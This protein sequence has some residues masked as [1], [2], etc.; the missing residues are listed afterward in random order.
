MKIQTR[1]EYCED[2]FPVWVVW[3]MDCGDFFFKLNICVA[4][5]SAEVADNPDLDRKKNQR[6]S[7]GSTADI[8]TSAQQ[9]Q[10][11]IIS[12]TP[13]G[14][15]FQPRQGGIPHLT[16]PTNRF[17]APLN[18]VLSPGTSVNREK[19]C[20]IPTILPAACM[21]VEVV[22]IS[23]LGKHIGLLGCFLICRQVRVNG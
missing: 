13:H 7:T 12:L 11:R 10:S 1:R 21:S 16:A 14:A 6:Q 23:V 9:T 17:A 19:S 8:K 20:L 18:R 15:R 22:C 3:L 2:G 5:I 4:T